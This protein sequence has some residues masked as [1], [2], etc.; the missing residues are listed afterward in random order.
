MGCLSLCTA[1]GSRHSMSSS[2]RPAEAPRD[3]CD[4]P[5]REAP[6][7]TRRCWWITYDFGPSVRRAFVADIAKYLAGWAGR[8]SVVTAAPPGGVPR[9]S[10]AGGALSAFSG[11]WPTVP[12]LRRLIRGVARV[13]PDVIARFEPGGRRGS[14][15][16]LRM[17]SAVLAFPDEGH[18]WILEQRCTRGQ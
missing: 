13:V 9:R 4:T 16:Q 11:R 7:D 1:S 12:A 3:R 17:R 15:A 10:G 18:G 14:A 6:G 5:T 8:I 2:W